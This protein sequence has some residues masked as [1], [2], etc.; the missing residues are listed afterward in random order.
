ML[1]WGAEG[2]GAPVHSSHMSYNLDILIRYYFE[3]WKRDLRTQWN[4][5]SIV[6]SARGDKMMHSLQND[7]LLEG[8]VGSLKRG[9][10]RDHVEIS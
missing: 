9:G 5:A 6:Q 10:H 4:I 2:G 7:R 1:L 3:I 8:T